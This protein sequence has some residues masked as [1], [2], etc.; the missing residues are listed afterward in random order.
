MMEK[1]EV[2]EGRTVFVVS[3]KAPLRKRKKV[4]RKSGSTERV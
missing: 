4:S 3:M 2:F 1:S